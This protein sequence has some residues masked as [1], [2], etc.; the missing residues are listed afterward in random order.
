MS[1]VAQT[2]ATRG[3]ALDRR[4]TRAVEKQI[5]AG[6]LTVGVWYWPVI[7]LAAVVI[8]LI[9]WR[10]DALDGSTVQYVVGSTRWFAFSLGVIIP[11]ALM[12]VHLTAGGTRRSLVNGLGLG[13]MWVGV[14]FGLA[15]AILYA[16]EQVV[17][18]LLGWEWD[19]GLGL[20]ENAGLVGFVVNTTGEGLVALAYFLTGAAVAAAFN[21]CGPWRGL[22]ILL[23]LGLPA[24]AA[25]IALYAGP[26]SALAEWMFGLD[27]PM[28]AVGSLLVLTAIALVIHVVTRLLLRDIPVKP[29]NS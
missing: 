14:A 19:R 28:P 4:A 2:L 3:S 29:S 12:R 26:A 1:A 20:A 7:A 15:S 17:W 16:I 25:D 9:Q 22:L 5:L 11:Q 6:T 8:A 24:V 23:G 13:A 18:N 21:R 10:I 27:G